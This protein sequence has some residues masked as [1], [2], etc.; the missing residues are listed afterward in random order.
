MR[1]R[2][3]GLASTNVHIHF[4]CGRYSQTKDPEE[5]ERRFNMEGHRV[6]SPRRYNI[7]PSQDAGVIVND[8]DRDR[9]QNDQRTSGGRG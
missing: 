7:A 5:L 2:A 3:S 8:G 1:K 9:L 4:A 6:L